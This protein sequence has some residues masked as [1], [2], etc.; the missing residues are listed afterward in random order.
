MAYEDYLLKLGEK[1]PETFAYLEA[2]CRIGIS[3]LPP[4]RKNIGRESVLDDLRD[5]E[6]EPASR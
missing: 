2:G 4:E 1:S 3:K 5:V 6:T